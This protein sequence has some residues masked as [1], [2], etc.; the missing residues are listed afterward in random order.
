MSESKTRVYCSGALF[1]DKEREEMAQI[2]AALEA[3]GFETFLPHRDGLEITPLASMLVNLGVENEQAHEL[4]E[5]A[6]FSLD[7]YQVVR[8][9]DAAVVNLNGRVPDE[10]AVAEAALAWSA[11]KVLVAYKDDP[12][13]L[14]FGKDNPMVSGLFE[15]QLYAGL[16]G[17]ISAIKAG[18]AEQGDQTK[19]VPTIEGKMNQALDLGAKIWG[20]LQSPDGL[21]AVAKA[22]V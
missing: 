13:S 12:R 7:A 2:A 19:A 14:Y 9:C 21:L 22:L 10:G 18:L 4:W 8:G 15:F 1:N 6:I 17:V 5:K 16:P 20:A 11:G 3:Q